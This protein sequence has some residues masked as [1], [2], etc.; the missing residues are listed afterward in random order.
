MINWTGNLKE[1]LRTGIESACVMKTVIC[2][3]CQMLQKLLKEGK[4]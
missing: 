3:N 4:I 1:T 2:R